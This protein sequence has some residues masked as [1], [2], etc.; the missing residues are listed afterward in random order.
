MVN[1][2]GTVYPCGLN[3]G[4]S[5]RF[6]VESRVWH[7]TPEEGQKT[8]QMKCCDYN[9]KDEVNSSNTLTWLEFELAYF[10]A[11]G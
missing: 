1:K 3:E 10:A 4:F 7:K 6:C 8:Y 2:I 5:S 9:N 11:A